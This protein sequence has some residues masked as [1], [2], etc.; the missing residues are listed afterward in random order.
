MSFIHT[1]INGVI[2]TKSPNIEM[3]SIC[4]AIIITNVILPLKQANEFGEDIFHKLIVCYA[5]NP[6]LNPGKIK[7]KMT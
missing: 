6:A 2:F 1:N 4:G 5:P 7:P 3:A